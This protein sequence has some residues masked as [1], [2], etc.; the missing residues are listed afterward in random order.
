MQNPRARPLSA[1][2][3]GQPQGTSSISSRIA[4]RSSFF[5]KIRP[6]PTPAWNLERFDQD[7]RVAALQGRGPRNWSRT[8]VTLLQDRAPEKAQGGGAGVGEDFKAKERR[9]LRSG[10]Q[11]ARKDKEM[12][13]IAG[14]WVC[15]R[16]GIH[17]NGPKGRA[18]GGWKRGGQVGPRQPIRRL[19]HSYYALKARWFKRRKAFDHWD[20]TRRCR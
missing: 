16:R 3:R 7:H 6:R 5:T 11:Y 18:R 20:P 4:V 2:D 10:H 1:V 15:R 14:A 17:G 8:D 13:G 19:S 12:L 9:P